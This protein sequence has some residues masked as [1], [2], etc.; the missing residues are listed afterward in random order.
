MDRDKQARAVALGVIWRGDELLVAAGYDSHKRERFYGP[1]GGTIEFGESGARAV[2][3]EY[4]EELG[5]DIRV[6]RYLGTLENIFTY[7]GEPGHEL[8]RIYEADALKPG[9][10]EEKERR[11]A[12]VEGLP[13]VIWKSFA[14]FSADRLYPHGLHELLSASRSDRRLG[15]VMERIRGEGAELIKRLAQTPD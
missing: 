2:E 10:Y 12:D 14:D 11:V 3:R 5:E 9:F 4:R 13:P 6:T 1:L 8:V 7:E 15:P